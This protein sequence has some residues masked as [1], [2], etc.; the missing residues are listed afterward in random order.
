M[1]SK[2][3]FIHAMKNGVELPGGNLIY[4]F[5]DTRRKVV[6]G[7]V[8]WF[9]DEGRVQHRFFADYKQAHA[10]AVDELRRLFKVE[11]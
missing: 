4:E 10:Y 5:R 3:E 6:S 1:I 7:G 2:R 8:Q 11:G 9:D